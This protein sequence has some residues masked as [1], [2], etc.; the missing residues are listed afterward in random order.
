MNRDMVPRIFSHAGV[1]YTTGYCGS[2]V[3]WANWAGRKAALQILGD[4][5][6]QS[7][8]DFRPPAM[9]PMFNG[10]PWFMPVVYGWLSFQDRQ[11]ARKR[12]LERAT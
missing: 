5:A 6:G 1:R 3:V 10:T 12:K 11:A 8:F 9:I 4:D 7:A 2:G